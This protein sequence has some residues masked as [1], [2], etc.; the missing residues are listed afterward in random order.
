MHLFFFFFLYS[1][2]IME[3]FFNPIVCIVRMCHKLT[4]YEWPFRLSTVFLLQ[5]MFQL[6]L[7][8]C[9]CLCVCRYFC[10]REIS[11]LVAVLNRLHILYV[12]GF[13]H[14]AIWPCKKVELIYTP[15]NYV[16]VM[17]LSLLHFTSLSSVCLTAGWKWHLIALICTY[18]LTSGADCWMSH[19]F[20][21]I[22]STSFVTSFQIDL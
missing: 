9:I 2:F 18:L 10:S 5:K 14:I 15:T 21:S 12:H 6:A 8:T 19:L 13:C 17:L 11:N 7:Y 20:P 4:F 1:R 16:W 22:M 3:W